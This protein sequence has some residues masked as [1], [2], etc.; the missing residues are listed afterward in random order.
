VSDPSLALWLYIAIIFT[1]FLASPTWGRVR[2][3]ITG[4]TVKKAN[5]VS[6]GN[7]QTSGTG[8]QQHG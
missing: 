7:T 2:G 8:D 1:Q 3:A 6:D 5:E 4:A